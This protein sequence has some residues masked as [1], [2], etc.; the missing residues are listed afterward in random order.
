MPSSPFRLLLPLLPS[1]VSA[2]SLPMAFST[3]VIVSVPAPT[4]F[5]AVATFRSMVTPDALVGVAHGVGPGPAG[6]RVVPGAG[7][8]GIVAVVTLEA[9]VASRS[10]ERI[11]TPG[12]DDRVVPGRPGENIGPRS[13]GD[14]LAVR[15][16]VAA[17]PGGLRG[18]GAQVDGECDRDP[19]ER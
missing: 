7:Q 9:V 15:D 19:G 14:V 16:R 1:R 12:A 8:E 4:V 3:A 2:P 17:G 18:R 10:R 13:A 11:A 5:C 6:R